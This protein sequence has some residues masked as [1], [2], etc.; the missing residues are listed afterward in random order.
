VRNSIAQPAV[1]PTSFGVALT[2][3]FVTGS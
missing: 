3:Y 1:Q 2:F